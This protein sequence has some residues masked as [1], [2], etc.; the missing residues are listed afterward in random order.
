MTVCQIFGSGAPPLDTGG[1]RRR[2][3]YP[4]NWL[5]GLW[6]QAK[7]LGTELTTCPLSKVIF[8]VQL[9]RKYINIGN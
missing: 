3:V 1:P 6:R 8:H 9:P 2:P 5:L 4:Y 7:Q